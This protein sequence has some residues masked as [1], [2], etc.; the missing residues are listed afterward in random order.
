MRATQKTF[1]IIYEKITE[2]DEIKK[3]GQ[4][5]K[6]L[7]RAL[8]KQLNKNRAGPMFF[9]SPEMDCFFRKL[10]K[11]KCFLLAMRG[12]ILMRALI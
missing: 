7:L 11:I 2:G 4:F 1:E 12:F 5:L 8:K 10:A 3:L 9:V 6:M